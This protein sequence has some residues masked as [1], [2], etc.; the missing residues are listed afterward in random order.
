M[1]GDSGAIAPYCSASFRP[2]ARPLSTAI[3]QWG[4]PG[5]AIRGAIGREKM[6][7]SAPG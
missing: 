3:W 5:G 7:E 6:A 1:R 2:I 4:H